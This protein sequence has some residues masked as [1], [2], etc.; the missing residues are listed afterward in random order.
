M[1]TD[2]RKNTKLTQYDVMKLLN[3]KQYAALLECQH[4]GWRLKFIRT[5]LLKEPAPVLYNANF[6]KIGILDSDGQIN[7]DLEI[8][9]RSFKPDTDQVR[10]PLQARETTNKA[11]WKEKRKD[12]VPVPDN[13]DELLSKLQLS[14]LRQIENFGWQLHFV[15]R[16][17][18]QEPIPVILSP[19]GDK[20]AT[21]ERDGRINMTPDSELRKE[22]PAKQIDS[23]AAMQAS[24]TKRA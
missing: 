15:R 9:V 3:Q 2:R 5:P 22:A 19:D 24:K 7:M 1:T 23:V 8:E 12:L 11:S 16:P 17:L 18:F 20:Y 14:A 4:F 21:L 6:D 13:L 10:K